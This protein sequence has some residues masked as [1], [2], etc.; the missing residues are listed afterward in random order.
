[1]DTEVVLSGI[2]FMESRLILKIGLRRKRIKHTLFYV[3]SKTKSVT[4]CIAV[5]QTLL[6]LFH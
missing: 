1:V 3:N 2:K 6:Y 5:S 4:N